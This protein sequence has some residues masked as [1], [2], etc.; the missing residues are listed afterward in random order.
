MSTVD[1]L[2]APRGVAPLALADAA[3]MPRELRGHELLYGWRG[4]CSTTP[5]WE[6]WWPPDRGLVALVAVIL[7]TEECP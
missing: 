6:R 7:G 1:S 4:R 2:F 3:R 5:S